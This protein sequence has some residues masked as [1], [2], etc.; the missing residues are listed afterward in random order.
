MQWSSDRNGGF[1]RADPAR[2][3][4]PLVQDP[5]YGYQ[6]INVEAQERYPFSHL[7]WMKRLVAMRRQHRVFGRGSLE[8]VGGPNRKVL[9]YLRRDEHETILIVA[10]LSRTVQP[11]ELDLQRFAGLI[12]VEMNGLAEFPRIGEQPYFLT[13][14]PYAFYWFTLAHEP[15]QIAPRAAA[16]TD[17]TTAIA[18]SL[19][20]LLVGVDWQNVL[21]GAT[22]QI[23]ERQALRPFLQRQRWFAAKSR[24]IRQVRFTD[25]APLRK[26]S[27]PSFV[28]IVS[29]VYTDGWYESYLVPLA[30]IAGEAADAALK[31]SPASV[32]ARIAGARNGVIA[33][34]LQD[35]DTCERMLALVDGGGKIATV[36]GSVRGV[37][38][39][40]AIDVPDER[41]WTRGPVEQS[42][43]VAF[44][45][46]RYVLKMFRRVE[47]TP[48]PEFEIG[49]FLT[50][51]GFTRSPALTGALEY[52]Q[53]GLEPGTL[54]VVQES[55][56]HQGSGWAF[57]IDDL[58]RYYERV[59]PRVR[60][61][62]GQDALEGQDLPP[63]PDLRP[64]PALPAVITPPALPATPSPPPFFAAVEHWYLATATTLG[65]RTAE[66]HATLA[67]G[68]EP[69]FAPEP[70]D[71][72]ALGRLADEMRL[73]GEQSLDVLAQSLGGL[74]DAPRL[75]ADAVLARRD[76]LLAR[77]DAIRSLD[78]AGLRIRI[79]GDY[80]LGQVLRTEE[81][82]VILD[83]EG[84]PARSIAERRAKHSPLKDVAGMLRSYSYA[85]YAALFAFS[86]HAPAEQAALEPWAD[87]W[88]H[89]TGEAFL[90]GYT[91]TAGV[92]PLLPDSEP[93]HRA[94]LEAFTLDKALYELGYEL[95]N[96]PD[97]VR[98]PLIGV[99][100]LI[101]QE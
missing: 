100:S 10:N 68:T 98:I 6:A 2:L 29:V 88:Q 19:P 89:W 33:D 51:H 63:R 86:V 90:K 39:A 91:T 71:R 69:A 99:R 74:Q 87:A 57:T 8:F 30:L 16:P 21:D 52:L 5:V 43:S 26:G 60:R 67:S 66:L 96:R 95:N 48:N 25:W 41:R 93:A 92:S 50:A 54:A 72:A 49:R 79:H 23:L 84:E 56:K 36:R 18:E 76:A 61:M 75:H 11:V 38:T 44:L 46:D 31:A 7:N 83:F 97:W 53:S 3:Y 34:G 14:G 42:N 4:A 28:T 82:F 78:R 17:A 80:H 81:D 77:F 37:R 65:R 35:D 70:L 15:M 101:G 9:A 55:V 32:L 20:S 45:S 22:R 58:R 13:L 27:A 64:P 40:A 94:L 59:S 24:E 85:A 73:H 12:P 47:P 62:Q 1:S